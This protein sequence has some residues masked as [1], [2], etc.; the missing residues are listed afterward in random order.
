MLIDDDGDGVML[1]ASFDSEAAARR[2]AS[3]LGGGA[4]VSASPAVDWSAVHEGP[5][6][7]QIG[8]ERLVLHVGPTFGWGGHPSTRLLLDWL[9][10]NPPAGLHVLDVGTGS[11]V[12]A[13]AAARLGAEHVTAIDVDPEAVAIATANAAS[14]GV[15]AA[16]SVSDASIDAVDGSFQLVMA[17]MLA[18]TIVELRAHLLRT[19]AGGVLAVSGITADQTLGIADALA[20]LDVV[21]RRTLDGWSALVLT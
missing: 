21:E 9:V 14:N 11:G 4:T 8:N 7:V 2:C 5:V 20:P 10:D 19:A 3:Q 13:A 16:V 17:N 1:T 6:D 12:L 18:G 15:A